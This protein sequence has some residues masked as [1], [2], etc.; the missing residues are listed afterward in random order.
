MHLSQNQPGKFLFLQ[1]LE[2]TS[3]LLLSKEEEKERKTRFSIG[4][5]ET[6]CSPVARQYS[7]TIVKEREREGE[8][9]GMDSAEW[10]EGGLAL[11]KH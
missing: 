9:S 2:K 1:D 10:D 6:G 3:H 7:G 5:V 4:N 8:R 11:I